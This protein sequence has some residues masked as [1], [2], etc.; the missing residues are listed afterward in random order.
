MKTLIV[1]DDHTSRLLMHAFLSPYGECR[2]ANDGKEGFEAFSA[3]IAQGEPY[4]LVCLDIMMPEM[5]GPTLLKKIRETEPRDGARTKVIMTTA[6]A[7][8]NTVYSLFKEACN[9]YLT[10]PVDRAKLTGHLRTLGLIQ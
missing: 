8:I 1:E 9:A 3:A 2:T 10:K 7:D 6:V 4:D 5:D